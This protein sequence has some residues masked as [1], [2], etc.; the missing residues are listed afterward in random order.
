MAQEH[1]LR[2]IL[3]KNLPPMQSD[4][5]YR[6]TFDALLSALLA[7]DASSQAEIAS[8]TEA[9]RKII[10]EDD[11]GPMVY[12]PRQVGPYTVSQAVGRSE[13]KY[14]AIAR[15]AIANIKGQS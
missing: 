7:A 6:E 11:T 8:L 2:A 10:S 4:N 5:A 12:E 9:L 3:L 13:G 15:A 14:A 1:T